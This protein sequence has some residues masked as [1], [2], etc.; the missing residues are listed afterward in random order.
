MISL[1]PV[2]L[3]PCPRTQVRPATASDDHTPTIAAALRR[4]D[5]ALL[6]WLAA[7]PA[8][9]VATRWMKT[10]RNEPFLEVEG[11]VYIAAT[12]FG[13]GYCRDGRVPPET[14]RLLECWPVGV[15]LAPQPGRSHGAALRTFSGVLSAGCSVW[16]ESG[17]P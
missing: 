3:K 4:R 5:Y 11:S 9:P 13:K 8:P 7:Q 2:S 1:E 14:R 6:A 12:H 17:H 16:M 15:A 10:A